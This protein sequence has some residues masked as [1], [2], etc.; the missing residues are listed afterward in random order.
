MPDVRM[1]MEVAPTRTILAHLKPLGVGTADCESLASYVDRL[2]AAH[3]V[4]SVELMDFVRLLPRSSR[5]SYEM[6][7]GRLPYW[8]GTPGLFSLRLAALTGQPSV[9]PLGMPW[10]DRS[11][12]LRASVRTTAVW[13]SKCW[14]E[15]VEE[16]RPAYHRVLWAFN[17]HEHCH[18]HGIPLDAACP[19]CGSVDQVNIT[20]LA[21][22]RRCRR[23]GNSLLSPTTRTGGNPAEA[24]KETRPLARV[25]E[26]LTAGMPALGKEARVLNANKALAAIE[27]RTGIKARTEAGLRVALCV[28]AGVPKVLASAQPRCRRQP[29]SIQNIA[30]LAVAARLPIVEVL[31]E[32]RRRR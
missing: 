14:R 17:F 12:S 20:G 8:G 27:A 15:D 30:R 4:S 16:G 5:E 11:I 21:N 26:E 24:L 10:A 1:K 31:Q 7:F 19:S 25:F 18:R 6:E 32:G 28:E 23:C 2:A 9:A 3:R 13:C 29:V 22:P